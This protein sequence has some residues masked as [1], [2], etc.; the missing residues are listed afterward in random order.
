LRAPLLDLTAKPRDHQNPPPPPSTLFSREER[1]SSKDER[2][3]RAF[4]RR[5][6]YLLEGSA[7]TVDAML[8][9]YGDV[10][11]LRQP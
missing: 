7:T 6:V 11:R 9:R 4:S 2:S 1:Y 5:L 10:L 3:V 8:D